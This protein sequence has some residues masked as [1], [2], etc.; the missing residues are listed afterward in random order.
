M[1][2]ELLVMMAV[3]TYFF[4]VILVEGKDDIVLCVVFVFL[5]VLI[6]NNFFL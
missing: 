2:G 3:L 6:L 4:K 1:F 5:N